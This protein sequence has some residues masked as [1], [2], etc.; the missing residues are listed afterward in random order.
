MGCGLWRPDTLGA[1]PVPHPC[2]RRVL[3]P[4]SGHG[5]PGG[6][7]KVTWLFCNSRGDQHAIVNGSALYDIEFGQH[8]IPVIEPLAAERV[9]AMREVLCRS[10][11]QRL[12]GLA[13]MGRVPIAGSPMGYAKLFLSS[14]GDGGGG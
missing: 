10:L 12:I 14:C 2:A 5:A 7:T 1:G 9:T 6:V 3:L 4:R 8:V 13:E 11:E